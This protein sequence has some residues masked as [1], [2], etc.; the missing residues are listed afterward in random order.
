MKRLRL[1]SIFIFVLF[2][3]Q[4]N[5]SFSQNDNLPY[6]L[7]GG[8]NG[9]GNIYNSNFKELPGIPNCCTDF[10]GAFGFG[11]SV[12]IGGEYI[13]DKL[14][15]DYKYRLNLL[16]SISDNSAKFSEDDF[17]GNVISGSTYEKGTVRHIIKPNITLLQ[18][19]PGIVLYP[20]EEM[21]LGV[22]LGLQLAIPLAKSFTQEED[23]I[24]PENVS[25][26]NGLRVR[27]LRDGALPNFAG[28]LLSASIGAR[29][30][31]YNY[32]NFSFLPEIQFQYYISKPISSISWNVLAL[33][34]GICVQYQ[35]PKYV[36]LPPPPEPPPPPPPPPPPIPKK[37]ELAME[38]YHSNQKLNDGDTIPFIIY[39]NEFKSVLPI[40]PILF[41]EKNSIKPISVNIY[42]NNKTQDEIFISE[43]ISYLKENPGISIKILSSSTNDEDSS[44]SNNRISSIT[45]LLFNGDIS[46]SRVSDET[47]V[48]PTTN[49][50]YDKLS[51]ESRYIKFEFSDNTKLLFYK[52]QKRKPVSTE[53]ISFTI[54]PKFIVEAKPAKF[55]GSVFIDGK[56]AT[57]FKE[58]FHSYVI[59]ETSIDST[60]L[61]IPKEISFSASLNDAEGKHKEQNLKFYFK[62]ERKILASFE[63]I[64][65]S[66]SDTNRINEY[67]LGFCEF[68]KYEF[69]VLNSDVIKIA[70]NAANVG[71]TI[72]IIPLT[73]NIGTVEH[74]SNLALQRANEARKLIDLNDSNS[75]ISV[76]TEFIYLNDTP[77]GRIMNRSVIIRILDKK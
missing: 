19:D 57:D 64:L 50:K 11:F 3:F 29:Y 10:K 22:R 70:K 27:N 18:I 62:P 21:P 26:E 37:I 45:N 31:V 39:E 15:Y 53:G 46:K 75:L 67:I 24:S 14:L 35:I 7:M 51:E 58:S 33:K 66:E 20:L 34:A 9:N 76:P 47:I 49:L 59:P 61:N 30:E 12:Y 48:V 28:I 74:N 71:K 16:L 68:D 54:Q 72:E 77:L 5:I 8:L 25:F 32:K 41:F 52:E 2:I 55:D 38:I 73:D 40:L 17:A 56:K 6:L 36:P 13:P 60:I 1:F 69:Y 23:L 42:N 65:E 63:N 43:L 4:L 44:T